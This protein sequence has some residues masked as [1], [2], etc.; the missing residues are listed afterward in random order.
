MSI[1]LFRVNVLDP[2]CLGAVTFCLRR[3]GSRL[4]PGCSTRKA[5]DPVEAFRV[6]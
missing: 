6:E 3:R 1:L 2:L 4:L 5:L